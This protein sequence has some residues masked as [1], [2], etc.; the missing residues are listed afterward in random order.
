[1]DLDPLAR[2]RRFWNALQ[3]RDP[4]ALS[5]LLADEFVATIEPGRRMDRRDLLAAVP[6]LLV[7]GY[8]IEEARATV[9]ATDCTIMTYRLSASGSFKGHPFAPKPLWVSSV[10]AH[11]DGQWQLVSYQETAIDA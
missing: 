7:D 11:R 2:E 3:A 8:A 5:N 9:I 1:M 6:D 10:W 4:A